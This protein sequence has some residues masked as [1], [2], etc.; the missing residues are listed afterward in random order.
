MT[1][2]Y[3]YFFD[4][5]MNIS[6]HSII[7]IQNKKNEYLQYY[8]KKWESYLF[9]N[10]KLPNGKDSNAIVNKVSKSLGVK[11]ELVEA[12]YCDY[13]KHKKFSQREKKEKEYIHYFYKVN[14][15]NELETDEF[16]INGINY[17]WLSYEELLQ[18][19]RIKETNNDIVQFVKEING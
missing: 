5:D 9:L 14:L 1:C 7:I 17:K 10:C 4:N 11:K 6:R 15:L 12:T 3:Q 13:K 16:E 19:K 8:D 2:H 18:D